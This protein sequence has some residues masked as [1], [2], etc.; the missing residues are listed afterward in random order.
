MKS[1]RF[2]ILGWMLL[3]NVVE[4]VAQTTAV[5]GTIVD[6]DTGEKLPFVQIYFVQSKSKKG[7]TTATQYGTMSDL[8]GNFSVSNNAGYTT[9]HFQMLGYKTETYTLRSGQSKKNVKV[10]MKPD[11]Y[12]LQDVVVTPKN[13]KKKY[14]RK[15]NPA[16]ELIRNVI[17]RKDSSQVKTTDHYTAGTYHRM[18]F[19]IDNFTPDFHKGL[20]KHIAFIEKYIDTTGVYPSLNVSIRENLGHEYYVRKPRREKKVIERKR[21]FGLESLLSTQSLESA[22]TAVFSDVDIYD[23]NMNLLFNRFVSPVS[24]GLAV[25]YYQ[26]YIM[27]TIQLDGDSVIDLAFVPV[28]SESYSFTGHLYIMNDSTYKIKK[29]SINIPQH[30]NMNFVSHYSVEHEYA[31]LDNGLWAPS[32]TSTSSPVGRKHSLHGKPRFTQV[33]ILIVP[34]TRRY[35]P[36]AY[37]WTPL[38]TTLHLSVQTSVIGINIVPNRC[39]DTKDPYSIW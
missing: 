23:D 17:A 35:S 2:L 12:G 8:D 16:V 15:G 32:R 7:E 1:I 11:V 24:D 33:L 38:S 26:Y 37:R 14:R 22:M 29:Y 5:S 30:I 18:S 10:K 36:T 3:W 34:L 21:I 13:G 9:L 39:R 19:A 31:R 20:W 28:N 25:S 6:A 27:D 4:S